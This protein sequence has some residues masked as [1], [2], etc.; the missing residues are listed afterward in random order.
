M[1]QKLLLNTTVRIAAGVTQ[2]LRTELAE[3]VNKMPLSEIDKRES[4]N[5][6]SLLTHDLNAV[7]EGLLSG[8]SQAFG[9]MVTLFGTLVLMLDCMLA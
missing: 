2:Q 9:G 4:A 7:S 6:A 1:L 8:L 3:H 5:V